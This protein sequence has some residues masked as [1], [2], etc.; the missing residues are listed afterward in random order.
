MRQQSTKQE[1]RLGP[2][3][4]S[5][6]PS[7]VRED[8]DGIVIRFRRFRVLRRARQLLADGQ[9]VEVGS[10][11][12]DLLIALLKTPGVLVT[13][14]QIVNCVWPFTSVE[15]SNLRAQIA[16]LRTL[17]GED[18]DVIKTVPG[19]GYIFAANVT[20]ESSDPAAAPPGRA[21][22]INMPPSD[23][24]SKVSQRPI[25]QE[26]TLA[27]VVVIDDDRDVRDALRGLLQ[28]VGWRVESFASVQ[29]FLCSARPVLPG[30]L[31][32]DVWLPGRS[33]LDFY[34]ELAQAN[35][36]LPVIFISGHADV[37]MSVRAM[38][39]GAIEFLIKPVRHEDL[40]NAIQLAIGPASGARS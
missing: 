2:M 10:R 16:A 37:P 38:K 3:H 4:Q 15:E 29:E 20:T 18:R 5:G 34:D 24:L 28:T 19:R 36:H 21:A 30:C 1:P 23:Q 27:T 14:D 22:S 26:R 13:K 40:L 35:V 25:P 39:A 32:L 6:Q 8:E 11:A 17:L 12:F 9:P 31:I 33:G 7:I